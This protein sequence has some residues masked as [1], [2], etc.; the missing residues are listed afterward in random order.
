VGGLFRDLIVLMAARAMFDIRVTLPFDHDARSCSRSGR[1]SLRGALSLQ[2]SSDPAERLRVGKPLGGLP[3]NASLRLAGERDTA[4]VLRKRRFRGLVV[5]VAWRRQTCADDPSTFVIDVLVR[6]ISPG[7]FRLRSMRGP[8]S[9]VAL[10]CRR[11]PCASAR[12]EKFGG[13]RSR[14]SISMVSSPKISPVRCTGRF[15][16]GRLLLEA[17][18]GASRG[19]GGGRFRPNGRCPFQRD[20]DR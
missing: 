19:P 9:G 18:H 16:F 2:A 20:P 1:R 6:L 13:P 14:R 17:R 8:I 4:G 10:F 5:A 15:F 11:H 7:E 12:S 3:F